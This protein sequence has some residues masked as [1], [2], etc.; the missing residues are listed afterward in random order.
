FPAVFSSRI[1]VLLR[2]LL[3]CAAGLLP[4]RSAAGPLDF[5]LPPQPAAD[6]LLAF[7]HQAKIEVLF[8]FDE[9]RQVKSAGVTG[10]YE[11]ENA[12]V[13]L[14]RDTGFAAR[15]NGKG[16]FVV[17]PLA[18]PTGS[19]KG[20]L[21]TAEG[22]PARGVRVA[23]PGTRQAMTTTDEQGEVDIASIPP[24]TY[25][26]FAAGTGFEP[27]KMTDLQ[28]LP[29]RVLTLDT[30]VLRAAED[31]V[32]LEPY[33]VEGDPVPLRPFDGSRASPGPQ[34]AAGNLDLPRSGDGPLPYMI[35]DRDQITRSGVV[36]LNEFLQREVLETDARTTGQDF[37]QGNVF[38]NSVF[39]GPT[40]LK[41]RGFGA[42]ETVVLV[43]GRRMPEM[44]TGF[45][46]ESDYRAPDVNLIPL[47]LVQQVEVL[48][49]SASALYSGNAV[50]GVINIVL[51]PE[52]DE[53]ATEVAATYTNALGGFGAPQSSVSLT[54]GR[55]LLDGAL[56]MRLNASFIRARPATEAQLGFHHGRI[57]EPESLTDAVY[58]ATPTVRGA[59]GA[60]LFGPGTSSLTSVAPGAD[61]TGGLA[62]FAGRPGVRSLDLFDPPG[63][64][65]YSP[66]S[67]DFPYGRRQRR[68]VF[69]GSAVYDILPWA[70]IG[71]D[72][73]HARTVVNR[74]Y[75]VLTGDLALR[76]DS[77]F[78]PFAQEVF[79]SLNETAP[80]L[81]ENY[82]EARLQFSSAVLGLIVKLP[83]KWQVALDT[84]YAHN[85]AKYRG[86][87]G[88]DAGR[89]QELVD[90][91][92]YNPLRDTQVHGPPGEFYDR[93]LIYFGG[94]G[95]FATLGDY[96]TL[97]AAVR[98]TNQLLVLPTG[99]GV[100]N[101]G[102]DYR[103]NHL[104]GTEAVKR[105]ADG[106]VADES[107][108][109]DG[110]TLQRF[111]L[112]G[113]LQAPLLPDRRRPH[114]LQAAD[115]DLAVRY[116]AA[117]T[118][119]ETNVAPTLGL[120]FDL[121]G[122]LSVRGSF[123]TSNRF[124]TPQMSRGVSAPGSSGAS[125]PEY[126]RILDPLR[127]QNYDIL[128]SDA[129][130]PDLRAE[131][132]ITQTVGLVYQRGE[133]HRARIGVDFV[134]TRKTHEL[135]GLDPQMVINLEEL[136]PGRVVREPLEPGDTHRAGRVSSVLTGAVNM[137]WR[138][139]QSWNASADYAWTECLGGSLEF[140]G[141]LVYTQR[142]DRQVQPTSAMV[143]ELR[144]PDGSASELLKYRANFG[145]SWT[146]HGYGFGLD[147]HY[148]HS[149]ILPTQEW[150]SQ[151]SDQIKPFWQ[152]DTYVQC[153]LGRWLPW[154]RA[155]HRLRGQ[156]RINNLFGAGFPKY[157]NE[158]TGAGAQPYG[159]WRGRTYS[160]S[161]TA[162]F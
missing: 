48:P 32:R 109:W 74:G 15:R 20:R 85:V 152:F 115:A 84:Q 58:G 139:S 6:A 9:L 73:I 55:T 103:R 11:P 64:M 25:R 40:N 47:S 45:S 133:T 8:S 44:L 24:G 83:A 132:A 156:L 13:H 104:A 71:L 151:G 36:N 114:W 141:R 112:F 102:A 41:L 92:L 142:Y 30:Q 43:N 98:L 12:L 39:G 67:V 60:A 100:V 127:N 53:N 37:N 5:D 22:A 130:D 86:L 33:V 99:R 159:D 128:A 29:N 72:V 131:S 96:D 95:R 160:L 101:L 117:D 116:V 135:V 65:A 161:L 70:Q 49:A 148:F 10:R 97:D 125:A 93:A 79:V 143:D 3:W 78:N 106:S 149:R 119:R 28:V 158:S 16:K 1:A 108:Q 7:S 154:D 147:G 136:L 145:A 68:A 80:V 88:V 121:A 129:I 124:P 105:F 107:S 34:R 51:R 91:G 137:A 118:S 144:Q 120:K 87:A 17:T 90:Q 89:W 27:L 59:D 111:S 126:A 122:G 113:E 110:R 14:L 57:R 140:Y 63:G 50:G 54:H 35:Y 82:S 26:L 56:R 162:T 75:D 2:C 157:A 123:T 76:A 23:L 77:P 38:R 150:P 66:S 62:A 146:N 153:D 81:G 19:I 69:V 94:R 18:R 134:D 42:D 52:A 31:L 46:N 4:A 138:H 155:R 21:L 61:G